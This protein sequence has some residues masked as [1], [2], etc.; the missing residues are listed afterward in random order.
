MLVPTLRHGGGSVRTLGCMG[1][2]GVE[3]MT[4]IDATMTACGYTKILA[5]KSL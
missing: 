4:F 5:D 1:A 2:K 3:K